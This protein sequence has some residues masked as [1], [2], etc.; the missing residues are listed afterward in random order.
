MGTSSISNLSIGNNLSLPGSAGSL[1]FLND[2]NNLTGSQNI[3]WDN[4]NNRLGL[5]NTTPN[6]SLDVSGK[7]SIGND[8]ATATPGT[9]RWNGTNFQGY[10]GNS[11]LLLDVQSPIV[12]NPWQIDATNTMV[13]LNNPLYNVGIGTTTPSAKLTVSGDSL[14]MG[15]IIVTGTSA[16]ATTTI[17]NLSV[18]STANL[19]GG[20][21]IGG[22][23][24]AGTSTLTD[25][26]VNGST[27]FP[28]FIKG[29][30]TTNASGT[31]SST[32]LDLAS[33]LFTGVLPVSKG[34]TGATT[35]ADARFNLGLTDT[36]TLASSTWLQTLNNL[37][38]LTNTSTARTNLGLGTLA[39]LD[40]LDNSNW[41]GVALSVTNGGTG[42]TDTPTARI[43]LDVPSTNGLGATGSWNINI[44]GNAA[45]A[46]AV[47]WNNVANKPIN[48]VLND[49]GNYNISVATSSF[50]TPNCGHIRD[51]QLCHKCSP[52]HN[53]RQCN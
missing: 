20:A 45:T 27:S 47:D 22:N 48:L 32:L 19:N 13:S 44:L 2:K 18:N 21:I 25:L 9:L 11:W 41:S 24:T 15:P 46:S 17:D 1:M 49:G 8:S 23:L 30:L 38:D 43:N 50:S 4:Q 10:N 31:V 12:I 5:G 7:L 35:T 42:A 16:L 52:R 51:I 3:F 40:T 36:A 33:D 34:G 6:Q 28:N 53:S 39:T 29:I 26:T 14:F 37:A